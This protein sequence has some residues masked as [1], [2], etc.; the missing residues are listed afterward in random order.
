MCTALHFKSTE[1]L[2]VNVSDF[3]HVVKRINDN[4]L[5]YMKLIHLYAFYVKM[6]ILYFMMESRD[7][8]DINGFR[9]TKFKFDN[10]RKNILQK[11]VCVFLRTRIKNCG[12]RGDSN[13][14]WG[15]YYPPGIWMI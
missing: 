3:V 9:D 6:H 12:I 14:R 11:I 4:E 13:K 7:V 8:H 1:I 15:F 5:P 2:L 10:G